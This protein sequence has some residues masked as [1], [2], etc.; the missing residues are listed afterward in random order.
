M[1]KALIC[2]NLKKYYGKVKAV[3]GISFYINR[4]EVYGLLGP[5]GAGKTTTLEVFEGL[6]K[7]DSGEVTILG[8]NA[9]TEIDRIKQRIGVQLQSTALGEKLKVGEAIRLF[10]S[11][12]DKQADY[13]WLI[14][15]MLLREKENTLY[16]HL[17]GGQKQ[18]LALALALVNDPDIIFLDEPTSGLDPQ[19]RRK[20]WDVIRKMKSMK[21]TVILTTHYMDEAEKLCDRVAIVDKGKIIAEDKPQNLIDTM[22]TNNRIHFRASSKF[23][24]KDLSTLA[25]VNNVFINDSEYIIQSRD[26]QKSLVALLDTAKKR[27]SE[28][29]ELKVTKA[30]L[31]DLFIEKTGRSLRD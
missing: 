4:G 3:D 30:T 22:E 14:D 21:K 20:L 19:A 6:R 15:L 28:L 24:K 8:I 31:E 26:L 9:F 25:A 7:P 17:S 1:G 27:G 5:N 16:E 13:D 23:T 2:K 18:R 29:S 11:F 10:R 12:Y